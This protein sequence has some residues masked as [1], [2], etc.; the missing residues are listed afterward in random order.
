MRDA[1]KNIEQSIIFDIG[2]NIG[3][4][5]L[6]AASIASKV[7]SFEPYGLVAD[8]LWDKV[9]S[10]NIQNVTLHRFGL[11]NE[12]QKYMFEAPTDCNTGTGK[13]ILD[14]LSKKEDLGEQ[15]LEVRRGDDLVRVLALETIHFV[16]IDVEGFEVEVLMGLRESLS[17]FRPF[18]FFEWNQDES[19][20][21][22]FQPYFPENYEFFA[23]EPT[24]VFLGFFC[25]QPFRL[26]NL[27]RLGSKC[28][29]RKQGCNFFAQPVEKPISLS[30]TE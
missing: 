25:K 8:Q 2:A 14:Q 7:H 16:K 18:V 5:T 11:G 27:M 3:H 21:A 24:P 13:F 4:H 19:S 17:R 12:N 10:N 29:A 22:A 9:T 23:F 15:A 6:F 30:F 1:L 28:E 20:V 26:T